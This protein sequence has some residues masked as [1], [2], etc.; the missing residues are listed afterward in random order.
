MNGRWHCAMCDNSDQTTSR[1]N[2]PPRIPPEPPV[3]ATAS[4]CRRLFLVLS[5]VRCQLSFALSRVSWPWGDG[6]VLYSDHAFHPFHPFT[7]FTLSPL[8]PFTPFT[9]SPLHPFTPS[10]VHTF[11]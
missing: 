6:G 10:P 2:T 8:H 1:P 9:R 7:P 5:V 3:V 11:T 4:D